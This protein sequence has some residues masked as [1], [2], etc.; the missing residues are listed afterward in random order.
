V[1]ADYATDSA[2]TSAVPLVKIALQPALTYFQ[3]IFLAFTHISAMSESEA[4]KP[5]FLILA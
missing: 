2:S 5:Q 1:L 3:K 4:E